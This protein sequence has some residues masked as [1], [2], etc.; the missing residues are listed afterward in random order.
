MRIGYAC[1]TVGVP[2][3]GYKSCILRNAT[4]LNLLNLIEHNLNVLDKVIDY[5]IENKIQMF[6]ISSDIIPFGSHPVNTVE[7]QNIFSDTLKAIG[8][9]AVKH[10]IRLSMHP[11]QY[12]VLNSPNPDVVARAILDLKYHCDVLDGLNLSSEHK[13]ILHIGGVYGNKEEALDRFMANYKKLDRAIKN[14]LIIENDD[15]SYTINDALFI[16]NRINIPV[17]FD[18]LHHA[19]LHPDNR[20]DEVTLINR[21]KQTWQPKDGVQKIHYSEQAMDKKIGAHSNTVTILPFMEFY[22][23]LNRADID[24]MLEVKDKN[25]SAKKCINVMTPDQMSLNMEREWRYYQYLVLEHSPLLYREIEEQLK[26]IKQY[27]IVLFY[28]LIEKALSQDVISQNIVLAA[29]QIWLYFEEQVTEKENHQFKKEILKIK[30]G[31]SSM[32]LKRFLFKLAKSYEV[33]SL[34]KSYYFK[35]LW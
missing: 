18:N 2:N 16:A 24:I 5:N 31:Q 19:I 8:E 30:N 13:I 17:V 27:H 7:W 1:L 10:G 28:S 26:E 11:G 6:R 23:R 34:Q 12:T 3:V 4:P 15:K 14:R 25:L 20:E 21:V 35:D 22:K 33:D 9:K 29:Q 32:T